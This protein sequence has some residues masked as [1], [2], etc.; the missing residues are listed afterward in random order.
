MNNNEVT[1]GLFNKFLAKI[2]E[3]DK[4]LDEKDFQINQLQTEL[5]FKSEELAAIKA[6]YLD[7]NIG[8]FQG[9]GDAK[10]VSLKKHSSHNADNVTSANV[11][12]KK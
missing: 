10:D 3:K 12:L 11:Q 5:R 8:S 7:V 6:K 2:D 1:E 9:L 4:K